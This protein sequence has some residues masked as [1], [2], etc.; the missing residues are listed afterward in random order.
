MYHH[1]VIKPKLR[2]KDLNCVLKMGNYDFFLCIIVFHPIFHRK[3][4]KLLQDSNSDRR[5]GRRS[6]L[7]NSPPRPLNVVQAVYG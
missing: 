3:T 1:R 6:T 5:T 7:T 2:A 4:C